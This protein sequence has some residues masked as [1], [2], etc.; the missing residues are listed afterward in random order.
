MTV[1]SYGEVMGVF[2]INDGKFVYQDR[3]QFDIAGAEVNTMI[4]LAKLG[5]SSQFITAV[6]NDAIGDAIRYQLNGEA[7]GTHFLTTLNNFSTGLM[8]K[9]RGVSNTIRVDYFRQNSAVN[10]YDI[11]PFFKDIFESATILYITGITPALSELTYNTTLDLI[12]EAKT[13]G[14]T[15][16]FDPNYRK[17][18]WTQDEFKCF[19]NKIAQDVDILLTGS[20]EAQII[21]G[22]KA[23]ETIA[24]ELNHKLLVI[25]DGSNGAFFANH[26][27]QCFKSAYHV[28]EI[29]SVGAGDAFA[30]GLIYGLEKYGLENL[31]QMSQYALAMG[32]LATTAYGDFYGLPTLNELEKFINHQLSD[33]ER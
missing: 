16:I 21:F 32:A 7:V 23:N 9:E 28:Q 31:A 13:R 2:S 6:G 18:L 14:L 3:A 15:V 5:L 29:D 20:S 10:H 25:K 27:A 12:K 22:N 1:I 26:K 11:N 17:K 4:G 8:T 30:A 19:Y 33:V 24:K